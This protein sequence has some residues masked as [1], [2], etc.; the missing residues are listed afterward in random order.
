[1]L[2]LRQKYEVE[3]NDLMQNLVTIFINNLYGVQIRKDNNDF[4][5]C[6]SEHWMETEYD[7]NVLDCSRL[8]E[9]I[10]R[11]KFLEEVGFDSDNYVKKTLPSHLGAFIISNS[12][13]I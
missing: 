12:N 8:P 2:A 10:C 5:I 11:V 9:G 3:H 13:E 1:M 6:K 7:E 4:Y